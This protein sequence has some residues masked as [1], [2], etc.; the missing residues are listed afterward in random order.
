MDC[1]RALKPFFL[2]MIISIHLPLANLEV[3]LIRTAKYHAQPSL[4]PLRLLSENKKREKKDNL[5]HDS[6]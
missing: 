6:R 4:L 3:Y 1:Q 2:I 5:K